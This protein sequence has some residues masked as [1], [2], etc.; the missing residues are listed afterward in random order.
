M[1]TRDERLKQIP[2][3]LR[4]TYEKSIKS[5]A[6]ALKSFCVECA[7][8]DRKVVRECTDTG[9]PLWHHRPYQ[10]KGEIEDDDHG[11]D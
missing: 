3:S 5:K 10:K 7:G 1:P 6:A 11:T 2:S 4:A 8:Y 9:C